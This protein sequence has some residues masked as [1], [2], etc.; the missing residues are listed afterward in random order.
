MISIP[1]LRFFVL[2][3]LLLT[4]SLFSPVVRAVDAPESD[5]L[6]AEELVESQK[7]RS[8]LFAPA[9]RTEDGR[10]TNWAGK[11][12]HG[13]IAT[14]FPFFGR[15]LAG[16]FRSR[17]GM[18]RRFAYAAERLRAFESDEAT[19]T[20]I[21]HSTL[22][23]QM[24]GVR[25]LT[26]PT[27]SEHPSPISWLGPRRFVAPGISLD[28]LPAID[29][30]VI[31]HNHY[32]HLDL[33]TLRALAERNQE[34]RF[35]VPLGN[36]P[37]LRKA[38]LDHVVELD[39]GETVEQGGVVV[40][41]LPA[42]HWSKRG[43]T[44]DLQALWASW[45]VV[46]AEHRFY[47]SG[48]SGYFKG[49]KEIGDRLGPFDLVGVAVGAYEPSA[50]MRS[51]HMNPEEAFQAARDLGARRAM[52]MHFGTFDLS[53]EPLD[54]APRRFL[55]AAREAAA[56][57]ANAAISMGGEKVRAAGFGREE[58]ETP[59]EPWVFAIGETRSVGGDAM[60]ESM[61]AVKAMKASGTESTY[62]SSETRTGGN[63]AAMIAGT[64]SGG[65]PGL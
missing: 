35:F 58:V 42:Q 2:S 10:F 55:A 19:A 33:P 36:G 29:F 26:D 13:T 28:D 22:L 50:M 43:L 20:W 45:A 21:G 6:A 15:R 48:D 39:W 64:S 27:W 24:D 1:S 62:E 53:D 9:P 17:P 25:F 46:G 14:R 32:D 52:A 61:E 3:G 12:P 40:H 41:C 44:D 37:L 30:V 23:V 5:A 57:A 4:C 59:P 34:M 7:Q 54:E 56:A 51:S 65:S 18:P 31:S 11:L 47:H 8:R 63:P 49:F 38:G 16:F 60:E